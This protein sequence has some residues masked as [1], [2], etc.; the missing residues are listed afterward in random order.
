MNVQIQELPGCKISVAMS[1]EAA[2]VDAAFARVYKDLNTRGRVPGF[3]PGRVPRALLI[4]HFGEDSVRRS[5]WGEL[6]S[7]ELE[8]AL[9]PLDVIGQPEL[10]DPDDNPPTEGE[11]FEITFGATVG[12]RVKMGD[13]DGMT[14]LQ[15]PAE[16][17]DED[18]EHTLNELR[19]THAEETAPERD[20]IE[21]GDKVDLSL[22]VTVEGEDKAADEVDQSI[23]VGQG[24]HFPPIDDKLVGL[25]V[26][27]TAEMEVTYPDDY[28]D[29]ALAG[30]KAAIRAT[31]KEF[32]ERKLPDLDDALAQ[33]VDAEKFKTLDDLK[34]EVK[35]QLDRQRARYSREEVE[36]Q[37][38]R[39]L[40]ERCQVELP[41][42]LV[43][44]TAAHETES[45]EA[46]LKEMGMALQDFQDMTGVDEETFVDR[47]IRR[48][49]RL[50]KVQA[51]LGELSKDLAAEEPSDD[52]IAAEAEVYAE[53]ENLDPNF[54]KQ[55]ATLQERFRNQLATRMQRRR[56]FDAIIAKADLQDV[57]VEEY[58]SKRE[59]LLTLP[60]D[61]AAAEPA[62]EEAAEE[63]PAEA[64][65]PAEAEGEQ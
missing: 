62:A 54:V 60:E 41:E 9:E 13:L 28:H 26:G 42:V 19:D 36:N 64:E 17:S 21:T 48:A 44:H 47:Q 63:A 55:A 31:V 5:V 18:I 49:T 32:K 51:I 61:V 39:G 33:K 11:A 37:V 8:K 2:E 30:K 50:L 23:V 43:A 29:E 12:P 57:S 1:F 3:R 34:A 22:G 10:P 20:T 46:E 35:R 7:E 38:V 15:P 25:H 45:L 40:L 65:K 27:D 6:I 24:E 58:R 16:A 52:E 14:L 59:E 4:R 53:E 56:L